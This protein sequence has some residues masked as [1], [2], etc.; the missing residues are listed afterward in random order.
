MGEYVATDAQSMYLAASR[1]FAL[2]TVYGA[3]SKEESSMDVAYTYTYDDDGTD[4]EEEVNFSVDLIQDSWQSAGRH[5]EPGPEAE[6]GS[7]PR[8]RDDLQRRADLPI[9]GP[10]G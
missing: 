3:Y 10:G 7:R 9:L 8:R 2:A 5:A 6:R 4:V 1:S